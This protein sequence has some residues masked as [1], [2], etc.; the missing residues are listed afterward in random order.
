MFCQTVSRLNFR[1]IKNICA[2]HYSQLY[3]W[4]I[5]HLNA[6][7][8]FHK[9]LTTYLCLNCTF[10][11]LIIAKL[12]L[13]PNLFKLLEHLCF[14][15]TSLSINVVAVKHFHDLFRFSFCSAID[16]IITMVSV[17]IPIAIFVLGANIICQ[18]IYLFVF[19]FFSQQTK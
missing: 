5:I 3:I 8:V 9:T 19:E 11:N 15:F 13:L 1:I 6:N 16:S 17:F 18:L 2:N 10:L 14:Y 7:C 12:L 4:H